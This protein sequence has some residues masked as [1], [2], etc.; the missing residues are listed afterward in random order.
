MRPSRVQEAIKVLRASVDEAPT[1]K[2]SDK[3][4]VGATKSKKVTKPKK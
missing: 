4:V 3:K 1:R 2:A